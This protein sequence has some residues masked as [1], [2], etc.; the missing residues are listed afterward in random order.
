MKFSNID[1]LPQH[2]ESIIRNSI[3]EDKL[4]KLMY[5]FVQE[6]IETFDSFFIK[7]NYAKFDPHVGETSCQIRAY[8][9][10]TITKRT[11]K[12]SSKRYQ[13]KINQLYNTLDKIDSLIKKKTKCKT[14]GL[15]IQDF[16]KNNVCY[17][18]LSKE[19]LFLIQSYFLTKYK[20]SLGK[21]ETYINYDNLI[22]A[23]NTNKKFVRKLVHDY[24][25]KLSKASCEFVIDISNISKLPNCTQILQS[26]QFND[27]DG[28]YVLPCYDFMKV[29]LVNLF[30]HEFP[31][32]FIIERYLKKELKEIVPLVY[33]SEKQDKNDFVLNDK[34]IPL[35]T[36]CFVVRGSVSYDNFFEE[37][38]NYIKRISALGVTDV[39][40]LNMAQHPQYSGNLL[41]KY[42]DNPY[43]STFESLLLKN[44]LEGKEEELLQ[45]K[46]KALKSGCCKEN[47]SLFYVKHVFC[48]T[49]KSQ[50]DKLNIKCLEELIL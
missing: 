23:T 43:K 26:L 1:L 5:F 24:Q 3:M 16:I 4:L 41:S 34:N 12:Y 17:Y 27:D 20:K 30:S 46:E 14:K 45:M 40:M 47:P 31:I 15:A 21:N 39:L 33:V 13:K 32:L 11:S 38:K 29:L 48:D 2:P 36:P 8:K 50:M 19:E 49:I 37:T 44:N 9:I 6:T 28:R 18:R 25:L 35:H 10:L 22:N 7:K 42:K